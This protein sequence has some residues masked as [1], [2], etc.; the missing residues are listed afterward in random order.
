MCALSI[1]NISLGVF[2]HNKTPTVNILKHFLSGAQYNNCHPPGCKAHGL[3][4]GLLHGGATMAA[5]TA[6]IG[7]TLCISQ[8]KLHIAPSRAT[9]VLDRLRGLIVNISKTQR[10][11]ACTRQGRAGW[12]HQQHCVALRH[13]RSAREDQ[14]HIQTHNANKPD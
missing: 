9:L 1:T 11:R 13:L 12:A 14:K 5:S 2:F 6:T 7:Q 3:L 8:T 4:L 10:P